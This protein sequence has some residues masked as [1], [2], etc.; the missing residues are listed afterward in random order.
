MGGF[1]EYEGNR[2]I[3]VLLPE[4]L[5]SYSLTGNGDFPRISEAEIEDRSKGDALSKGF[6]VVQTSW[7][8]AQCIARGVKRLP[9]T[10]LELITVA[11]AVLNFVIYILWWDKPLNV[12][13]GVRV[14]KKRNTRE[15]ADD[16][17]VEAAVGFWVAL[18]DALS[19]LPAAIIRGPAW[20]GDRFLD[21]VSKLPAAAAIVHGPDTAA[22]GDLWL[23]RVILWPVFKPFQIIRGRDDAYKN[24]KRV[25]TFYPG[26]WYGDA[27]R[28]GLV[29]M[30]TALA[31][32]GIHRIGWSFVSPTN[33]ER[34]LWRVASTFTI[35]V[36]ILPLPLSFIFGRLRN[37]YRHFRWL[38]TLFILLSFFLYVFGRLALIVLS[39][40]CLRSLPPTAYRVVHWAS[41]I[42]H[43]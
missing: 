41:F 8:M 31:F 28:G 29:V 38:E 33:T 36:P 11:F 1:M 9:I 3:R 24:P 2:P 34:T 20:P 27:L 17:A 26:E 25:G 32:G 40:L 4:D 39:L 14:Y 19:E 7:F 15:P 16:G 6:V 21:A 12:V 22:G 23:L 13:R 30:A 10:E 42:P 43:V 5:E 18:R 37:N 35:G